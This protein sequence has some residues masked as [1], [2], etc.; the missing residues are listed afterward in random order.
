MADL[1]PGPAAQAIS[2]SDRLRRP[3][4]GGGAHTLSHDAHH[5]PEQIVAPANRVMQRDGEALGARPAAHAPE[6]A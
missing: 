1:D 6:C 3:L 5:A 4:A 2:R